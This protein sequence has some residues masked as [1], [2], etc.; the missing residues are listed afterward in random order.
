MET[1]KNIYD[2]LDAAREDLEKAFLKGNKA[3]GIRARKQ[4]QEV[5]ALVQTL[6]QEVTEATKRPK[7]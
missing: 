2:A 7:A 4:L 3:A 6:R 5:K 1:Y